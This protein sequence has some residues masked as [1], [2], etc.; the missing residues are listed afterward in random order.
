MRTKKLLPRRR[1]QGVVLVMA[2]I[3]M[4]VFSA[5]SVSLAT[6]TGT[7]IQIAKNHRVANRARYAAESGLEVM[8]YWLSQVSISGTTSDSQRFNAICTSLQ[9]VLADANATNLNATQSGSILSIPSVSLAGG[10]SDQF[11]AALQAVDVNSLRLSV[12]GYHDTVQRTIQVDYLFGSKANSVFDFGAATKGPLSISGNIELNGVNIAIESN[13]YIE[14]LDETLALSIVGNSQ[15]GG[16]VKI[17]NPLGMVDLQGGQAGIGGE[18]GQN[19]IDNHVEFGVPLAEFPEPN[20][21][22]FESYAIN[23]IDANTDTSA[24]ATFE[25]IRIPAGLNPHFSG[26]ITLKGVTFIETP[27]VVTFSGTVDMTGIIVGNGSENDDSGTN[28]LIFQGDVDSLPISTLP[29]ESQ[30]EGLHEQ[31]GTFI[32]TPGFA[33]SFTG[34][35]STLSG[36]IAGNGI[37]FSGNA[38]GTINGSIIN[39]S[40]QEMTLSGNSDLYFN[41]SGLDDIPAGFVPEITLAFDA[42]SYRELTLQ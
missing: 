22:Q 29:A 16:N 3:F 27:N 15:I 5:F 9:S 8:R 1:R 18:T 19:A 35:F 31:V 14:S 41:R 32:M 25:N 30:Y 37:T 2:M 21:A 4:V 39:Y 6:F 26:S 24:D 13:A 11:T 17:A 34:N 23:V 20:P 38:G 12:T 7:N 10:S 36:A 42:S 40:H 28:Q 33:I